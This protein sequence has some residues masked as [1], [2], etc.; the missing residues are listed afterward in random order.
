MDAGVCSFP[1]MQA[2]LVPANVRHTASILKAEVAQVRVARHDRR[3][4]Q[5]A[6]VPKV[7]HPQHVRCRICEQTFRVEQAAVRK[8]RKVV[9]KVR[10][11]EH[12]VG[13]CAVRFGRGVVKAQD[14]IVVPVHN[15]KRAGGR[16][17]QPN[18]CQYMNAGSCSHGHLHC[19]SATRK[20]EL[21]F[22]FCAARPSQTTAAPRKGGMQSASR[23]ANSRGTTSSKP[24]IPNS[25]L[26]NC[27][28]DHQTDPS[29][30]TT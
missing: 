22:Y 27:R 21:A 10:L 17:C 9:G 14:A 12:I 26:L 13:V 16:E 5:Y 28:A 20:N 24:T 8:A 25:G 30:R 19:D 6:V 4:A 7:R 11:P 2:G 18:A 1:I 3:K 15:E 29:A 23:A